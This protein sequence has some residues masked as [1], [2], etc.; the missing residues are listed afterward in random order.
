MSSTRTDYILVYSRLCCKELIQLPPK[1]PPAQTKVDT[2]AHPFREQHVPISQIT[3]DD[4]V[5]GNVLHPTRHFNCQSSGHTDSMLL[6]L[7]RCCN[8]RT[9]SHRHCWRC[10]LLLL[11][12]LHCLF[13]MLLLLP[14]R[15]ESVEKPAEQAPTQHQLHLCICAY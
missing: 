8:C 6:C 11:L 4:I 9:A 3:M 5:L 7:Y 1:K 15:L 14:P 13:L 2:L 10:R 12:L